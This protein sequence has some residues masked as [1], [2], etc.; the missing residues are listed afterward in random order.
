MAAPCASPVTSF[1]WSDD[2]G[3]K[4]IH[5]L[6]VAEDFRVTVRLRADSHT[7]PLLKALHAHEVE[8]DARERFGDRIAVSGSGDQAFL[9]ADSESAARHAQTSVS[10]CSQRRAGKASSS[11]IAGTTPKRSGRT[12]ACRCRQRPR[13]NRPSTRSS[14]N[15]KPPSPGRPG[16]PSGS[17]ASR[18]ASHHDAHA[19]AETL[20][21]EGI[22]NIIRRW[23][24]LIVGTADEDDADTLAERLKGELPPG[25]T[26]HIEPGSGLAWEF[27][28]KN[29]FAVF[30]GLGS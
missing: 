17:C 3:R 30:G 5:T 7:E 9:Y 13:R 25:G 15:R 18:L 27:A 2:A 4:L 29:P 6:P 12:R 23:K 28:P 21:A 22:T 24:F 26:I 1:E 19:L 14:S 16:L 11:S 10:N 20:A 8:D